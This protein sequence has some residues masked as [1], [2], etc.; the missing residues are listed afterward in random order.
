MK[1]VYYLPDIHNP[2]WREVVSGIE[3]KAGPKGVHIECVSADHDDKHQL[4]QLNEYANKNPDGIFISPVDMKGISQISKNIIKLG[5]PVVAIDQNLGGFATASVIS[6]NVKGG[7]LAATYIGDR[8][9]GGKPVVHI[10]CEEGLQNIML[11]S[12][13]FVEEL[14]RRGL[15]IIKEIQANSSRESAYSQMTK[16]LIDHP[17]F[18]AIFAEN[19]AMALGAIEALNAEKRFPWPLIIGYDG[20]PEALRA[21]REGQMEATIAQDP[22]A[23]GET[24]M[25]IIGGIIEGKKVSALTTV[26]PWL[27]TK[28]TLAGDSVPK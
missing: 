13:S 12:S 24:A 5:I 3:K 15:K 7:I 20:V 8:L 9:G 14:K 11:R 10:K 16:Y 2:F 25:E 4:T 18:D 22:V 21:I 17:S 26:L 23:L 6:G 19:D 28:K 27:V 1:V